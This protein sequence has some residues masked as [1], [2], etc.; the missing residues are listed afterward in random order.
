MSKLTVYGAAVIAALLLQGTAQ[1]AV[2]NVSVWTGAPNGVDS[3]NLANLA[4]VPTGAADATFT[5]NGPLSWFDI[6]PQNTTPAGN[7]AKNFLNIASISGFASP[8]GAYA[9]SA[10]FGNTS[11]SIAGDAYDS[12]FI[13][14]GTYYSSADTLASITH[15]DGVSVYVNGAPVFQFAAET[16][17]RTDQFTLPG[18]GLKQFALYYVSAN[19]APSVLDFAPPVPEPATWAMMLIGFAGVGFMAYRCQKRRSPL[20]VA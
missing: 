17:A 10:A 14:T 11:L 9:D 15:D 20:V 7:L 5:Y 19:G 8:S 16:A 2:Y 12:F 13:I 4:N 1:A 6:E 3:S 18:G